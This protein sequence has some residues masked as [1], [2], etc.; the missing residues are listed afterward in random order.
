MTPEKAM[1]S[2]LRADHTDDVLASVLGMDEAA[3]AA[4]RADGTVA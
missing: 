2:P 3:I 4:L 1:P